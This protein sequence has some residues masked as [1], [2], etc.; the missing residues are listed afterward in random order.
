MSAAPRYSEEQHEAFR[1]MTS[2]ERWTLTCELMES[3]WRVLMALP[4]EERERRLEAIREG[5][6]LSNE[7]LA[8]AL[9]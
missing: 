8:A 9:K 4:P 5:H 3:E 7:A 1:R 2:E 6:R